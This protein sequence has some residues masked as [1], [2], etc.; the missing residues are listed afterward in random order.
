MTDTNQPSVPPPVGPPAAP[1]PTRSTG[2]FVAG[3]I[4]TI[5][6]GLWTLGGLANLAIAAS[7]FADDPGY[8]VGRLIGGLV[9]PIAVL[10]IGIVLLRRS[11]PKAQ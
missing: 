5:L 6:G 10:V 4:M 7:A 9:L 8:A 11:K 1:A 3:L 2:K